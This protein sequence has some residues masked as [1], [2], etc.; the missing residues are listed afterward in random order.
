MIRI[1]LVDDQNLVQQGIKS[2]LDKEPDLKVIGT[3]KDGRTA[4]RHIDKLRPDIVLLDIEMPGMDG[5]TVTKHLTRI[6]PQIKVIILSSHEDKKYLTR[7]LMA[8]AKAYILKS[9]L[10]TDLKQSIIAVSN[11]YSQIESRL[12]AKIFDPSNLKINSSKKTTQHSKPA[13]VATHEPPSETPATEADRTLDPD[14]MLVER[15][16]SVSLSEAAVAETSNQTMQA[17]STI[18][19]LNSKA[20]PK[21][22][23]SYL[24]NNKDLTKD[25]DSDL[26]ESVVEIPSSEDSERSLPVSQ[27]LTEGDSDLSESVVEIPSSEDSERSLPVSQDL[28]EGDSDLSESVVEI[29]SSE[30][31]NRLLPAKVIQSATELSATVESYSDRILVV[32]IDSKERVRQTAPSAIADRTELVRLWKEKTARYK[33]LIDRSGSWLDDYRKRIM[34]LLREWYEKGW[35]ANIGLATLGTITAVIIHL[36]F[37]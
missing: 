15:E 36:M 31:S 25:D 8:G 21:I 11:G 37:S 13:P 17:A 2:L 35:I 33:P 9:S 1:L 7:A 29:P 26:S 23:L 16:D 22:N 24:D 28:T 32:T 4:V 6:A 5:I 30:D 12:L 18:S 34:P 27:D 20:V 3:V 19:S 14:P 10:M